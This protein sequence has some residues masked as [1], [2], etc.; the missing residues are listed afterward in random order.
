MTEVQHDTDIHEALP[1]DGRWEFNEEV[2]AVFDE[3]LERSIPQ[4]HAMRRTVFEI[5]RRFGGESPWVMDLGCS[6]GDAIAP[7]VEEGWA[8]TGLEVSQP[9]VDAA[10][11]RFRSDE[12]VEILQTDLRK[13]RVRGA[14]RSADLV[15]AIL[16]LQFVPIN[17]RQRIVSDC[18]AALKHGGAM[19]VVEK[20]L[21]DGT[22]MD[23]LM[24]DVYHETKQLAGYSREEV[25]RKQMALEGVLVPVTADWNIDLLRRAGFREVDTFWA[26]CNFRGF[27]A[28]K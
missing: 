24:V 20:V 1:D 22:Q 11:E 28:I 13:E 15:L 10:R 2:T 8:A 6:R 5:G 7:F 3:M 23:E 19:V 21:G 4:Y 25:E 14:S 26:W 12:S 9:M 18:C 27:L 17:Y 16:T